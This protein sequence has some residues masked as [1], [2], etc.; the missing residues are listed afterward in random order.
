LPTEASTRIG[1]LQ[2]APP[3]VDIENAIF[4][5]P[6]GLKRPS[7]QTAYRLPCGPAVNS[8]SSSLVRRWVPLID[9]EP[10]CCWATIVGPDQVLPPSV[11]RMIATRAALRWLPPLPPLFRSRR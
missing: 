8:G 3:S 4:D 7:C 2:V 10:T 11:E 1:V 6:L 9:T 5:A